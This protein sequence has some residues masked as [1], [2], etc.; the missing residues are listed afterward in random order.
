VTGTGSFA[1]RP[2]LPAPRVAASPVTVPLANAID[3]QWVPELARPSS[4][5]S[6]Q[7]SVVRRGRSG[8]GCQAVQDGT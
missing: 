5:T 8:W 6:S 7:T 3:V 4:S 1:G 2:G